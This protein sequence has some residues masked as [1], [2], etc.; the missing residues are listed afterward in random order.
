[1]FTAEESQEDGLFSTPI[2][3]RG[4]SPKPEPEKVSPTAERVAENVPPT[5]KGTKSKLRSGPCFK[6]ST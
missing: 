4:S 5:R 3:V 1:M 2:R 6:C